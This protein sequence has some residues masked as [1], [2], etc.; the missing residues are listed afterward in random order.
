V[1]IPLLNTKLL[2]PPRRPR[3]S[4][5]VR[6]RLT[7]RLS[8]TDDQ[9]LTLVSAPAGFGKTT[10]VSEWIPSSE[11]CVL[12]VSLD[13]SDNDP[14]R[15]WAYFI[16]AVQ[17]LG[18]DLG[19]SALALLR[20]SPPPPIESVLTLL[21][22]DVAAFP[23]RFMLVL[24]DYH[25]V[26]APAIHA[27]L[28]FLLDHLPHQMQ[29]L[30]VS[31]SDPPLPL[32][33]WRVHRQLTELRAA[34]LRFTPD[35]AATFLN[36]VMGLNLS[37]DEIAA[38]D[39]RTE[40][41]IA[42][43]QLAALSM[44]GH[45][46]VGS[47]I[48]SFSGSHTYIIDYLA[49]EVV[50]RQSADIQSFLL[51]TSILDRMCGPLCDAV[52]ERV[53][54]RA[55]LEA[56]QHGNLF[57]MPLDNE[58]RW[59][60]YH[61]LFAEVLRGYLRQVQPDPSPEL[62]R[63]ASVWFEQNGLMVEAVSH[64][65][66]AA[67]FERAA[68]LIERSTESMLKLGGH[69][70]LQGWLGRLPEDIMRSH[71]RLCLARATAFIASQQLAEAESYLAEAELVA[72]AESTDP[73]SSTLHS[74]DPGLS[75][76]ILG[77]AAI[78]RTSIALFHSD[79]PRTIEL[80]QQALA[81]LPADNARLRGQ[82]LMYLAMAYEQSGNLVEVSRFAA[83]A[84]ELSEAAGDFHTAFVAV[85]YQV[86]AARRRGHLH[87]AAKI[88]RHALQLATERGVER[89][90]IL[91]GLHIA[92]A[93]L[94]YEWNELDTAHFHAGEAAELSRRGGLWRLLALS[95]AP[96]ALILWAQGDQ[97][98]ALETMRQG[99]ELARQHRLPPG[100]MLWVTGW[101]V[102]LWLAQGNVAAAA[103]WAQASGLSVN[104]ELDHLREPVHIAL[105]RALI[106]QSELDKALPF[107]ARLEQ[108][109]QDAGRLQTVIEILALQVIALQ[110][111]GD[112]AEALNTLERA[113]SLAEPEGF[114]RVFVDEGEPMRVLLKRMKDEGGRLK[115]YVVKL[116]ATFEVTR[117]PHPSTLLPQPLLV[118][119]LSER[120]LE[121]LHLLAQGASNQ[122]IA[123]QLVIAVTTVK[124]H[125]GNIYSKLD[126]ATRTQAIARARELNLV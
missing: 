52:L 38:L 112:R 5:V 125:V 66:A 27:A 100:Y 10:L 85:A 97:A 81:Y 55:T 88:H 22:N 109:A 77:E 43:L 90:P 113:L 25:L 70:T 111:R 47:F 102:R 93:E 76:S 62:H 104:D 119:P 99:D 115:P 107:L 74:E 61:H 116:L 6:P 95:H 72:L 92:I 41:W 50:Q 18:A 23:D 11:R 48:R 12:W 126:V 8:T 65:L 17:M 57:V 21:L 31:R 40:G 63:R 114:I 20:S 101:Q 68:H 108:T 58:R 16:A 60:R 13:V 7:D 15:F 36:R 75:A 120:E 59:Y 34:D 44:Q 123:D 83:D 89:M 106:A 3:D 71:P 33:R 53:D 35:E 49:E 110:M 86:I 80:A 39:T 28:I 103:S 29:L 121:V 37:A 87:Q 24:D 78:L 4:V 79:W 51:Q 91:A 54:S 124:K 42:G 2:I 69:T 117:E 73:V 32:A 96:L 67:D 46:D 122:E 82:A 98:A 94:L 1:A 84:S 26:E 64:A 30:I 105:A 45:D 56:L 19:A 9:R 118:E 14:V